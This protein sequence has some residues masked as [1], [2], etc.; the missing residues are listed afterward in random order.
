VKYLIGYG[1]WPQANKQA[2]I[3]MH[4][5]NAVPLLLDSLSLTPTVLLHIEIQDLSLSNKLIDCPVVNSV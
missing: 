3:H 5:H 2:N 1:K 4:V